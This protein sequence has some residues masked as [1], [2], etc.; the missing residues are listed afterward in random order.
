MSTPPKPPS[1]GYERPN[2]RHRCG[3]GAEWGTPCP[4]GPNPDGTC[5]QSELPC[6][7]RATL[8]VRRGWITVW[9]S[10]VTALL[11][12]AGFHFGSKGSKHPRSA[13][14]GPLSTSHAAFTAEAGC[15]ACHAAHERDVAGLLTAVIKPHGFNE[16]CSSCHSFAGPAATP[17]NA[18]F[19][20]TRGPQTTDCRQCHTEHKGSLADISRLT[21][22]QCQ[23]CHKQ[24]FQRF[25]LDHPPFP[26]NFPRLVGATIKF[27]HAS[28]FKDHFQKPDNP[29]GPIVTC[30]TCHESAPSRP[31]VTTAG[32]EVSCARCHEL[33]TRQTELTLLRLPDPATKPQEFDAADATPFMATRLTGT[34]QLYGERLRALL[35][36]IAGKGPKELLATSVPS[37]NAARL[38]AGLSPELLA[39]PL[40]T[41]LKGEA[42]SLS[43]N[44]PV[45]GWYWFDDLT[46]EL[47]HRPAG[48]A[49]PV[50][51][52]WL[53]HTSADPASPFKAELR[54]PQ[55]GPGRCAKCHVLEGAA[56]STPW[57]YAPRTSKA[58]T[59]FAHGTHLGL[60][61]CIECHALDATVDYNRQ[62]SLPSSPPVST[63]H[64]VMAAS[65]TECHG[66]TKVSQDCRL[67]HRYHTE[68]VTHLRIPQAIG[69]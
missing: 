27:D 29:P 16:A 9:A 33:Q 7:P 47:R 60:R 58:Q 31:N 6:V 67:C 39:A 53:D 26:A 32:F 15:A 68:A 66:K 37:T 8:R 56:L 3:R 4:E 25:D 23:T 64:G 65:C 40:K 14:P 11:L 13:D 38:I 55:K 18:A 52:A 20:P 5:P 41:W 34:N 1:D 36:S 50:L 12:A 59:R 46:P 28:H 30:A 54:H 35:G 69:K 49:D 61:T 48:H 45:S 51:R 62:F 22:D 43:P 44:A 42:P 10:L 21:G 24:Q 17:H 57:T 63:L 2:C 19:V